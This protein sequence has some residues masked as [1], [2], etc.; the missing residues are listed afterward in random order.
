MTTRTDTIAKIARANIPL[1]ETLEAEKTADMTYAIAR[2][3]AKEAEAHQISPH[4]WTSEIRDRAKAAFFQ[5]YMADHKEDRR[6]ARI[7]NVE[8]NRMARLK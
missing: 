6:L 8:I 5:L 2:R 3:I 4:T 7:L 1:I